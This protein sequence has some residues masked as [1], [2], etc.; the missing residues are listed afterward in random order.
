MNP[1]PRH[2]EQELFRQAKETFNPIF[3]DIVQRERVDS[4]L[5]E[6]AFPAY[7]HPNVLINRIMWDRLHVVYEYINRY[8]ASR[9]LDFGCG[10]GVG[11]WLLNAAG[12]Q[13]VMFDTEYKP[14]HLI[15]RHLT[16]PANIAIKTLAEL[17]AQDA[18]AF[19]FIIALDVLEHITDQNSYVGLFRHLLRNHGEVIVSGPTEN[20]L[21]QIGRAIAGRQFSGTY[22]VSNIRNIRQQL[23][24]EANIK[25]LATLYPFFPLF[26]VF[27]AVL[28]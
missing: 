4:V 22:H 10:S 18:H 28:K 3:R 23:A 26:E 1:D 20:I 21:Y 5:A 16:F 8:P 11:S 19:D 17:R 2:H 6:A 15:Q 27:A 25:Q 14:L 24:R 7:A 12:H 9:V 13:V